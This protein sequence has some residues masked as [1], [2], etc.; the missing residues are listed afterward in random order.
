MDGWDEWS[1]PNGRVYYTHQTQVSWVYN[2]FSGSSSQDYTSGQ[3][4]LIGRIGSFYTNHPQ[5]YSIG[6]YQDV[7]G[8]SGFVTHVTEDNYVTVSDKP[9]PKP[10]L[11]V[12]L[13]KFSHGRKIWQR[14]FC[15]LNLEYCNPFF[16]YGLINSEKGC[17]YLS[18]L[19]DMQMH[20]EDDGPV[21]H[22]IIRVANAGESQISTWSGTNRA[23]DA[24]ANKQAY[25]FA[26]TIF[27]FKPIDNNVNSVLD[28]YRYYKCT[29][30][31]TSEQY[32]E[33]RRQL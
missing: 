11:K 17:L 33:L 8:L 26:Q 6:R 9:P 3:I 16:S 27:K 2:G 19:L 32:E 21:L 29:W 15:K 7:S 25:F 22:L 5:N 18:E 23:P 1:F 24:L 12:V 31:R 30:P 4:H 14:R 20:R 28:S 13:D 10:I